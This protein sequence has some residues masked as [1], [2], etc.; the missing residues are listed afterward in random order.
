MP[1]TDLFLFQL[2]QDDSS[3]W[4]IHAPQL[5][6]G[7]N[8]GGYTNQPAFITDDT[9]F[10]SVRKTSE[11]QNEIYALDL[12][13]LSLTRVTRTPQNEFS[14][15]GHPD[16]DS[17]SCVRQETARDTM[18]QQV[19]IYPLDKS[20]NGRPAFSDVRNVGYH[21]WLTEE[22]IALFLVGEPVRLALGN[23]MADTYRI[24]VSDIGRCLQRTPS[25]NLAYVHKYTDE[26]WYL[27]EM[28]VET[29][30]SEIIT[31]VPI[32]SEDFVLTAE[33][34]CFMG[35]GSL[36]SV[37]DPAISDEWVPVLDLSMY[38]ISK[39]TRLA[40]NSRNQ[41]AVVAVKE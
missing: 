24:W 41:L 29:R 32:G 12:H 31:R 30:R 6:S 8:P 19:Y 10:V 36:L 33:G 16:G 35:H 13:A 17:F 39:I 25:G 37:F 34:V 15:L 18:D 20:E 5:L 2:T 21:C 38:G 1:A 7:F 26:F 40:I 9:L 27:K 11:D 4:H 22:K 14:P 28:D 3:R 23:T